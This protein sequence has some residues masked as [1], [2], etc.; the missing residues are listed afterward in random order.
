MNAQANICTAVMLHVEKKESGH[1]LMKRSVLLS[2]LLL[3]E[4]FGNEQMQLLQHL[5]RVFCAVMQHIKV[6]HEKKVE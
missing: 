6:D 4:K 1:W 2:F 3:V 5:L